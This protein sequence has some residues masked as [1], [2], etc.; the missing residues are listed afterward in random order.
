MA[1]QRKFQINAGAAEDQRSA[2]WLAV[3]ELDMKPH[4][5]AVLTEALE[6]AVHRVMI[7]RGR[8]SAGEAKTWELQKKLPIVGI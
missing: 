4:E 7:G 2:I 3:T 1:V 6:K 5:I 8:V